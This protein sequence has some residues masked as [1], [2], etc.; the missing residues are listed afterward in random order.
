MQEMVMWRHSQFTPTI[1]P[2]SSFSVLK[3]TRLTQSKLQSTVQGAIHSAVNVH[4]FAYEKTRIRISQTN[5]EKQAGLCYWRDSLNR[6][7]NCRPFYQSLTGLCLFKL[8]A[9]DFMC[10]RLSGYCLAICLLFL[11]QITSS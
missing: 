2:L 3:P 10:N 5:N 8:T 7:I 11:S 4:L 6:P 9:A 1:P